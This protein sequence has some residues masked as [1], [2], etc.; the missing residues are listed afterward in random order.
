MLLYCQGLA[1]YVP[2]S[3]NSFEVRG[4]RSS[5]WETSLKLFIG[6]FVR[7]SN[8]CWVRSNTGEQVRRKRRK[9][10]CGILMHDVIPKRSF[11]TL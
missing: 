4:C 8:S 2:Q 5:V 9:Y 11:E 1:S 6:R 7:A 10:K 3:L